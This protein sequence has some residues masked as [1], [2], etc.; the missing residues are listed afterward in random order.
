MTISQLS[1]RRVLR[2]GRNGQLYD[3]NPRLY[4]EDAYEIGGDRT[5]ESTV[6]DLAGAAANSTEYAFYVGDELISITSDGTATETEIHAALKVAF[7]ANPVAFGLATCVA[8]ATELTIAGRFEGIAVSITAAD[9]LLTVV[10]T[11]A[12]TGAGM[13]F[14]RAVV[15]GSD[16]DNVE[17]PAP[18][19]AEAD[20]VGVS[21]MTYDEVSNTIG[22]GTVAGYRA[23]TSARILRT[24]RM[25][26]EGTQ[27]DAATRASD[28]FIGCASAE[29]GQFFTATAA[30]RVQI[31]DGSIKWLKAN[32]IEIRRG[33]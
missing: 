8:T 31:T 13:P 20:F 32:V 29:A 18:G 7:D 3:S 6:V 16:A 12:V 2:I 19:A 4:H 1:V 14:G 27:A 10:V 25:I 26:V 11:P 15:E 21:I 23:G 33:L 28:V 9:A 5:A 24:G 22:D 17:L 30:D